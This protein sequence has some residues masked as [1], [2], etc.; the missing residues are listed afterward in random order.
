MFACAANRRRR[1]LAGAAALALASGAG[2][3]SS[4]EE[5]AYRR[6]TEGDPAPEFAAQ[7]AAGDTVS[8]AALR[9]EVVLLNIW[10]TWCMPCRQEMPGLQVLHHRFGGDGLRVVGVSIDGSTSADQV[11]QFIQDYGVTFTILRD[12]SERVTRAFRSIGVPETYLIG[13]D[14]KIAKR[15]I[16]RFEPEARPT[17]DAVQDALEA[18]A[19]GN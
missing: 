12:P 10:A 11:T 4:D 8:L 1:L 16:G 15:W 5:A 6:L 7:T 19:P 2:C 17:V 3:S 18:A 14:G 13:R 9:G